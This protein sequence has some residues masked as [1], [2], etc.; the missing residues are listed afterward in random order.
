MR[1]WNG[2]SGT[3]PPQLSKLQ[4]QLRREIGTGKMWVETRETTRRSEDGKAHAGI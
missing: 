1:I 2:K 3:L 4:E